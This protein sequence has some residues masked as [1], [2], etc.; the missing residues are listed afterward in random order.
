MVRRGGWVGRT[1]SRWPGRWRRGVR[2]LGVCGRGRCCSRVPACCRVPGPGLGCGWG[3][4]LCRVGLVWGSR[5]RCRGAWRGAWA[6]PV[7]ARR[8]ARCV[9]V[10]GRA[11]WAVPVVCAPALVWAG[12]CTWWLA[13]ASRALV[14]WPWGASREP[15]G[16]ERGRSTVCRWRPC[17][18]ALGS[19]HGGT[20]GSVSAGGHAR[21]QA[22]SWS[23]LGYEK[24]PVL[25]ALGWEL[26]HLWVGFRLP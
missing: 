19:R 3:S 2:G 5:A 22:S 6:S 7:G 15:C 11:G 10:R 20:A 9:S 16:L 23:G 21:V 12:A 13:W 1:A 26:T 4:G 24:T 25:E 17:D 14:R 8:P 18:W